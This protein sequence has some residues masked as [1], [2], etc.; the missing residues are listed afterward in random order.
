MHAG[1]VSEQAV[2]EDVSSNSNGDGVSYLA[3]ICTSWLGS[4]KLHVGNIILY[5]Y[6][7][8]NWNIGIYYRLDGQGNVR[9]G[10]FG[11]AEDIYT[12]GYYRQGKT[13]TVKLP[14]KWMAPESLRDGLFSAKSDV[15]Y[16]CM[17]ICIINSH[18][19]SR[20]YATWWCIVVIWYHMLGDIQWW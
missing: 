3:E 13:D 8:T 16:S 4:K 6:L 5:A 10:D 9:V 20:V 7:I 1:T 11:L 12:R 2:A 14:F 15:V 17:I 18:S 19:K